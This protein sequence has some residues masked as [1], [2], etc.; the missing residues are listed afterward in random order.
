MAGP[1]TFI[2]YSWTSP[3]HERWVMDL[4]TELVEKGVQIILDKWHL[5]EGQDAVQF[6]ESMVV[7]PDVKK[8]II[9][10]DKH[11]AEKADKRRGGVGTE[12]QIMSGEIYKKTD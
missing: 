4:A 7:D 6:M 11:Y 5:R 1:K 10:S 2:S 8:V 3:A 9:I 12:S